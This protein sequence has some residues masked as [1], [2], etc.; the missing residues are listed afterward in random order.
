MIHRRH[1]PA[2][3]YAVRQAL[4]TKPLKEQARDKCQL[5]SGGV[6]ASD[7]SGEGSWCILKQLRR[8]LQAHMCLKV[9]MQS[10]K[11]GWVD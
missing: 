8:G 10:A 2:A 5:G 3:A 1:V 4:H 9:D 7:W 6:R 11:L